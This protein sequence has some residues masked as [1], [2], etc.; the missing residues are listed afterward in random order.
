[1]KRRAGH[2][3]QDFAGFLP[4]T[5]GLIAAPWAPA[6]LSLFRGVAELSS[7]CQQITATSGHSSVTMAA[8]TVKVCLHLLS[9]ED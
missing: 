2:P 5:R 3:C 9:P 1:M 7:H 8:F 4:P 6:S